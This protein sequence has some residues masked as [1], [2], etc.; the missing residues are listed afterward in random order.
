MADMELRTP[1]G[2][3][4]LYRACAMAERGEP[5][6]RQLRFD[7]Q[8]LLLGQRDVGHHRGAQVLGISDQDRRHLA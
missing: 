7:G 3:E 2:R 4:L 1:D 6:A 8:G 5:G